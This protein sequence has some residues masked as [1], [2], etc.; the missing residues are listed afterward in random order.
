MRIDFDQM[1]MV[2]HDIF[3][4]STILFYFEHAVSTTK[5]QA[6]FTQILSVQIGSELSPREHFWQRRF[7][8]NCLPKISM[9]I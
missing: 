2:F 1:G 9:T 4:L 8:L 5:Y 6:V 3:L 7:E